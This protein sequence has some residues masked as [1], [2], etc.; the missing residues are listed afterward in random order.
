MNTPRPRL[1]EETIER[2][3][4]QYR[5][6]ETEWQITIS[7]AVIEEHIKFVNTC[8]EYLWPANELES[9]LQNKAYLLQRKIKIWHEKVDFNNQETRDKIVSWEY[10]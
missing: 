3:R 7:S 9:Y 2:L 5:D 6:L 4:Q 8:W 1:D 10:L